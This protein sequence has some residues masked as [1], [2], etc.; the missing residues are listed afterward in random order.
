MSHP[1]YYLVRSLVE[2]LGGSMTYERENYQHGAWVISI[3]DKS[4]VI[5][6][7]GNQSFPELDQLHVQKVKDPRQWDDYLNKLVPDAQARLLSLLG[8]SLIPQKE[9]EDLAQIIERTKWVFAWRYANNYP[10]EY[11]TKTKD[12]C[13][14]DD[15]AR[16][17]DCIEQYGVVEPFLK[18]HH[19]Y[20]YFQDRKYWHMG[21][22]DSADPAEWPNVI[23]RTWV[24]V[25][26][27]AENVKHV[28]SAEEVELQMRLWEVRLEKATDRKIPNKKIWL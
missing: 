22:P 28:W 23:N 27:H 7:T 24:D 3:G 1:A 19:K 8:I 10:H 21:D 26:R 13:K 17:I 14:P 12:L 11:T 16:L 25:R 20:F 2:Y 18:Y 5:E 9:T 6:A 4:K 15:H